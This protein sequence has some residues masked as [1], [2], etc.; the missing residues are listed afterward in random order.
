MS[1]LENYEIVGIF[2]FIILNSIVS[3]F[4]IIPAVNIFVALSFQKM[5]YINE[6]KMKEGT[7][8]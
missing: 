5:S 7:P 3:S 2:F 6:C 1:V 8:L 4:L